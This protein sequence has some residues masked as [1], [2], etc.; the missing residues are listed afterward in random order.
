MQA[1]IDRLALKIASFQHNKRECLAVMSTTCNKWSSTNRHKR[2]TIT[3][4]H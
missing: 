2:Q 4:D 1:R 3:L